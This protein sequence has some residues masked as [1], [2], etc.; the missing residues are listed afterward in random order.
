M[1]KYILLSLLLS[2][3]LSVHS[4]NDFATITKHVTNDYVFADLNAGKEFTAI[5]DEVNSWCKK[6]SI[7]KA[8]LLRIKILILLHSII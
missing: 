6:Y 3:C 5:K 1:R 7:C 8:S 4:Q 2:A